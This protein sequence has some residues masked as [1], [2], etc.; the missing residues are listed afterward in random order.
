[1]ELLSIFSKEN[2]KTYSI[3]SCNILAYLV[4]FSDQA[5]K[6]KKIYFKKMSYSFSKKLF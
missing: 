6:I 5:R 4:H 1:M 2:Q 3:W